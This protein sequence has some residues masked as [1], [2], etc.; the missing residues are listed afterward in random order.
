MNPRSRIRWK[1][2]LALTALPWIGVLLL[3]FLPAWERYSHIRSV[4]VLGAVLVSLLLAVAWLLTISGL[5]WRTRGKTL[6]ILLALGGA[7]AGLLRNDSLT[8]D[9]LPQF[10]WR[11][12]PRTWE[13]LAPL[14]VTLPA[15]GGQLA[16]TTDQPGDS[17]RFMGPEGGNWVD[18]GMLSGDWC[19][20]P[21][22][23]L[24]RRPVGP[25]WG[26]ITVAGEYA[27]TQSNAARRKSRSPTASAPGTRFGNIPKK[28][29]SRK[30]WAAT[31]RAPRPQ[32]TT[33]KSTPSAP[34][35][36]WSA[37]TAAP[38][39]SSGAATPW[40]KTVRKT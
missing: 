11:W 14:R 19:D 35:A 18:S 16:F 9:A 40:R 38:G 7:F 2:L 13:A 33:G 6:L 20:V 32:P 22:K 1:S 15:G 28:R 23:E 26:G 29:N 10:S 8:G 12:Q 27:I 5:A 3:F 17:P 31:V 37:W 39:H 24:W 21:P 36:S 34:P 4:G 25:G 30:R